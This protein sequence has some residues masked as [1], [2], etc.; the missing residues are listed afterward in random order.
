MSQVMKLRAALNRIAKAAVAATTVP[1]AVVSTGDPGR[2]WWGVVRE[3]FAGAW[4]RGVTVDPTHTL[5]AFSAVYS[6]ITLISSDIAKLRPMLVEKIEGVWEETQTAA[7]HARVLV[8]PNGYQNRIQFLSQWVLSK[9]I[10]GN[11]YVLKERDARGVVTALHILNPRLVTVL[12]TEDGGVYY[13]IGKDK[14]SQVATPTAVPASEIIHD[15]DACFFHPLV[16]VPPIFACG[17]SATQGNRIQ[18]N[19]AKFFENMSAPSGQLTGPGTIDDITAERLKKDFEERFSGQNIGR[20]LVTGDGLK[21]E[22]MTIP[23]QQSQLIEQ[24]RW[25][26]EDVA[27]CFRVPLHKIASDLGLKFNNM[28]AMNQD[29]YSQTLQYLIESI[30]LCLTEGLEVPPKYMVQIDVA[31]LL[32]MDPAERAK[33]YES[34]INA[35]YLKPNEARIAENKRPVEGGDTPYMQQQNW[36]LAQLAKRPPPS[37]TPAPAAPSAT[38]ALPA[39]GKDVDEELI[40]QRAVDEACAALDKIIRGLDVLTEAA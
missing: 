28:G 16:G 23:A 40:T 22:Q 32:R 10:H 11:T 29:Y 27:R 9:L 25:T 30:E 2:S 15:R 3:S 38:P 36:P 18:S 12:V 24:L 17:I 39:P 14:L 33:S 8:K 1:P 35:G 4:Q 7:P 19:S 34:G 20:L 37:S 21:Y 31:A 6:C 5:L 13:Q 26:V